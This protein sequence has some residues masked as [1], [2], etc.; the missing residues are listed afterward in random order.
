MALT[1]IVNLADRLVNQSQPQTEQSSADSTPT[2]SQG[3][4]TSKSSASPVASVTA[5]D[6]FTS[7][8]QTPAAG[9][10]AQAAGLFSVATFSLFTA[11]AKF[12]LGDSGSGSSAAPAAKP[13]SVASNV[14]SPATI[15]TAASST[16]NPSAQNTTSAPSSGNSP[17][18]ATSANADNASALT[19]APV[20]STVSN[21]PFS[22]ISA[23]SATTAL[24]LIPPSSVAQSASV[25]SELQ[26][27]NTALSALGLP[28]SDIAVI[29]RIAA[30][31]KDFSPA[32]Y[33]DLL[34][35]FET[36]A[37]SQ[38]AP[39]AATFPSTTSATATTAPTTGASALDVINGANTLS[40]ANVAAITPG[41]QPSSPQTNLNTSNPAP[42]VANGAAGAIPKESRAAGATFQVQDLVIRFTSITETQTNNASPQSSPQST[43]NSKTI[44]R[45]SSEPVSQ[46]NGLNLGVEEISVT[47][48]N[49]LGQRA[50]VHVAQSGS[51]KNST[52]SS[53][54]SGTFL[55]KSA[56]A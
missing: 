23:T 14:Q 17:A 47:L 34:H 24:A 15:T 40:S 32:A 50:H 54:A 12:L 45:D 21:L 41:A 43:T 4:S 13:A 51:N 38:L 29:D 16:V 22:A 46:L 10:T 55:A 26:S 2:T 39:A 28:Q 9:A 27:L 49:S 1:G 7:S 20:N 53:L 31:L 3:S 5:A 11:A 19:T 44:S 56:N 52:S 8:A 42:A 35:Q 33:S 6:E 36:L 37:Q 30:L 25:N 18:I 48:N